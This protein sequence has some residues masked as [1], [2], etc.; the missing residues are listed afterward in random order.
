M[1]A[2]V[3]QPPGEGAQTFAALPFQWQFF[4]VAEA[5]GIRC[6]QAQSG[7]FVFADKIQFA[8]GGKDRLDSGHWQ[9]DPN[10]LSGAVACVEQHGELAVG[11]FRA[12]AQQVGALADQADQ[13]RQQADALAI[14]DDAE[15]QVEPVVAS[16]IR[17]FSE[18]AIDFADIEMEVFHFDHP[19]T[20]AQVWQVLQER[21]PVLLGWQTEVFM[22]FSK[23]IGHIVF[24]RLLE[25]EALQF[26][27]QRLFSLGLA[28]N[29]DEVATVVIADRRFPIR[30]P[31][32]PLF[33]VLVTE[34]SQV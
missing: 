30:G 23:A 14:D 11:C 29:G 9:A 8:E 21:Q 1:H 17:D 32:Y 26:P 25:A 31:D 19:A 24:L 28:D 6:A 15:F 7:E 4:E 18:P 2:V 10:P 16:F 3:A 33:V 22:P 12:T 20:G 5:G 13:H 27:A 34:T